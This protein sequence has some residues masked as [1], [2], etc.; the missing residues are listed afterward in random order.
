[1]NEKDVKA[2]LVSLI[3][4]LLHGKHIADMIERA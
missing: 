1:M 4:Q 2:E 3:I